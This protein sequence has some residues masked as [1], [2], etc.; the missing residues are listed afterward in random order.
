MGQECEKN[1]IIPNISAKN[2][3]IFISDALR[4]D[5]VPKS[6]QEM[7]VSL[8]TV[9]QST[10]TN[11]SIPT[12]LTGLYPSKHGIFAFNH[13]VSDSVNS[14][15]D[16][17]RFEVSYETMNTWWQEA[18]PIYDMF[19]ID[20][21]DCDFNSVNEPFISVFHDKG[22]HAPFDGKSFGDF[23]RRKDIQK[24]YQHNVSES[25][26]RF[27]E[28]LDILEDRGLRDDTLVVFISDHGE[29]LGE[30][31]GLYGHGH[32]MCP[33]LVYVPTVFVHPDLPHSD[34]HRKGI[35]EHIDILPTVYDILSVT[36]DDMDGQSLA[37]AGLKE[38][39]L[40]YQ[41]DRYNIKWVDRGYEARGYF[42]RN[43]G[44]VFHE[45]DLTNRLAHFVMFRLNGHNLSPMWRRLLSPTI[46][47]KAEAILS[48]QLTFGDPA[49]SIKEA[50]EVLD[51][52]AVGTGSDRNEIDLDSDTREAMQDLGY[53]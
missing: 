44:Y 8:K 9:A 26:A 36:S 42:E 52:G 24:S 40:S 23:D 15:F 30:Y 16:N 2:A 19:D 32:P 1:N 10:A 14:L 39:G 35:A 45:A 5:S 51:K 46:I 7:G 6:I 43:A 12:I 49:I 18:S 17:P 47:Q 3:V 37:S 22:G 25:E 34:Q 29:L 48:N 50:Q 13:Q 4:W 31:G 53:L 33:E 41:I 27:H 38:F 28:L 11:T 20:E 21:C